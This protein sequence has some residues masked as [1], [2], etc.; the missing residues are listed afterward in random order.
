M[1][2]IIKPGKIIRYKFICQVCGCE[3]IADLEDLEQYGILFECNCP[4][5][6]KLNF[7]TRIEYEED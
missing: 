7:S 2:R 4:N 6:S 3:Y 5:C 1:I